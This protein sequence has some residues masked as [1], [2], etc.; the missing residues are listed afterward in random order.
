MD[1]AIQQFLQTGTLVLAFAV[2]IATF[3][4]RRIV[5]T[6]VPKLAKKADENEKGATYET[7]FARW[8]NQVILYAIP[9]TLGASAGLINMPFIFGE[10]IQT[11]AGRCFFGAVVGW[12]SSFFYKVFRKML[13]KHVKVEDPGDGL[14]G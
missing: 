3:F 12:F 7:A 4:V 10:N 14:P 1:Q 2:F 6:A 11:L 5:E 8:W 13:V 9:V